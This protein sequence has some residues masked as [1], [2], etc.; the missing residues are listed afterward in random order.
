MNHPKESVMSAL[1]AFSSIPLRAARWSAIHPWRAIGVWA[2]LVAVSVGLAAVVP[3][4]E[5][6]DADY[7]LGES[8]R[9]E[10]MIVDA[11]PRLATQ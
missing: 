9:A 10:A 3:T 1:T 11:E 2:L 6:S 7:R 4:E 8:G 5:T